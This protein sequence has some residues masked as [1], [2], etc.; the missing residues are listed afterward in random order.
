MDLI[1]DPPTP[2]R[3]GKRLPAVLCQHRKKQ[4]AIEESQ[5]E[6]HNKE[7]TQLK[8]KRPEVGSFKSDPG[9]A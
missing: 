5:V 8:G 6:G 7:L 4:P 1:V 3:I 9:Y 2:Y